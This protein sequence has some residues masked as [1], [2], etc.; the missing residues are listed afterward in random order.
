MMKRLA[1]L[2]FAL[3][4][5]VPAAAQVTTGV[6]AG[7][8]VDP[9]Q[10]YFGGHVETRNLVEN[11]TFRPNVEVGIGDDLTLIAFNFELAYKFRAGRPW[12]PYVAAGPA[13]NVVDTDSDT[14]ANGG[15]NF[16]IGAEHRGGL[17]GEVK[18]GMIDSPDFKFG[19]G[20]RF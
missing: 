18:F 12:R 20:F 6:R 15:I 19:I 16:A 1:A 5:A 9:D 7:A 10:F 13:L 11:V 2:S 4:L 8:S 14:S 17:F 3:L